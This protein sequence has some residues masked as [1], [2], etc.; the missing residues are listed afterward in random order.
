MRLYDSRIRE[1]YRAVRP[2][3]P[4]LQYHNME[5]LIDVSNSC[6]RYALL[7]GLNPH[8]IFILETA[9]LLHDII[10]VPRKEDNE[11]KSVEK[12]KDILLRLNYSREEIKEVSRL[13][14]A[15]KYPTNPQ[16]IL[17][18]IICDADLDNL[19]RDDFFRKCELF[20]LEK[21]TDKKKW[22]SKI[23]VNFLSQM[24]YYTASAKRLRVAKL[25]ENL[26]KLKGLK[27]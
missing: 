4:G 8:N 24:R 27:W 23:S 19:G 1:L 5:H 11:E 13:I 18:M 15:T 3:A 20:R 2:T 26:K 10:Y 22:Y 21:K 25:K 17:E 12:S 9:G 6:K 16:D 14:L 7:E